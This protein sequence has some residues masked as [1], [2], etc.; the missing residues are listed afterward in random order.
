MKVILIRKGFDSGTGGWPSIILPDKKMISFPIPDSTDNLKYSDIKTFEDGKSLYEIMKNLKRKPKIIINKDKFD[1][2]EETHCHFDPDICNYALEREKGWKGIF[3][4][5]DQAEK[6]LENNKVKEEDL[7]IFFGWFK[8]VE[9]IK[10]ETY[11]YIGKDK[12]VMFGYLQIDKILHPKY[13]KIP[14]QFR[15][16]PHIIN[17]KDFDNDSN[18]I[19]IAKD[20]CTFDKNIRG[21]G[22]FKYN[23][24]LDLTK[25][26]LS[27]SRW[28]LP[29][30]FKGLDITYHKDT[31]W[32]DGYF[33]STY[34]FQEAVI[35]ENPKVSK[36]AQ[37]LVI[38]YSTNRIK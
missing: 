6:V 23:E 21:Y 4:Q 34:R 32:K 11:K 22:M 25:K 1:F 12:H 7:F 30:F 14:E 33:Q 35:Q 36:W 28:D 16:H 9:E 24:E 2:T 3:G 18:T 37:D 15:N 27:R 13:D 19:Y 17:Q 5:I 10:G 29:E 26:G 20:V 38:K 31:A 8:N